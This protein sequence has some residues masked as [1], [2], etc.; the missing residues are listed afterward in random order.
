MGMNFEEPSPRTETPIHVP[1]TLVPGASASIID[2]LNKI[3]AELKESHSL[4]EVPTAG[5]FI[6]SP[7][8][9]SGNNGRVLFGAPKLRITQLVL[10][11]SGALTFTIQVSSSAWLV[12]PPTFA[13]VFTPI[14]L[15]LSLVLDRGT[16]LQILAGAATW[17]GYAIGFPE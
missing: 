6:L 3:L 5:T 15:P 8:S 13:G 16:S 9:A 4:S 11:A 1:P 14:T 10:L 17:A 12:L 7:D 2:A